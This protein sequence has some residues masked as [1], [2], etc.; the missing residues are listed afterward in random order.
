M[1]HLKKATTMTE[2]PKPAR[3]WHDHITLVIAVIGVILGACA[4]GLTSCQISTLRENA[5]RQMRAYVSVKIGQKG[6]T[7]FEPN[8]SAELELELQNSGQTPALD[9]SHSSI[10]FPRPYPLPKEMDL[11]VPVPETA[12]SDTTLHPRE[13]GV[14]FKLNRTIEPPQFEAIKT[15]VDRLYAF[16]RIKYRDIFGFQHWTRFCISFRGEGPNLT[17][18]DKCARNN[19]TDDN[20]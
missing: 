8:K 19:D 5:Q 18:W 7:N 11:T 20:H 13:I 2:T 6:V 17:D 12:G 1:G 14:G 16:G 15:G 3:D 10:L 9:V 4:L